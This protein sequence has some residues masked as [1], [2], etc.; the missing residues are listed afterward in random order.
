MSELGP[1]HQGGIESPVQLTWAVTC[2]MTDLVRA[3]TREEA[4]AKFRKQYLKSLPPNL[5]YSFGQI[6]ASPG[7]LAE[8]EI[9]IETSDVGVFITHLP[10]GET[11]GCN[12]HDSFI[13]NK[14]AALNGLA[15]QL[16]E[17]SGRIALENTIGVPPAEATDV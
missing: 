14:A 7:P 15:A 16:A 1:E 17:H 12:E 6:V 10:T 4:K 13:R 8:S 2:K 11:Y 5:A 9:Q 3:T